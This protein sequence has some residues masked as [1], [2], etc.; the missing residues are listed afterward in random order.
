MPSA[1]G[2]V[3]VQSPVVLTNVSPDGVGSATETVVAL[4]GPLLVTV[5][6]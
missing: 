3:V 1:Q 5:I 4:E 2:N 6:V